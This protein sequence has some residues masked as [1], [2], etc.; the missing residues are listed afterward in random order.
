MQKLIGTLGVLSLVMFL[1]ETA[2][3]VI[4]TAAD[5]FQA[6]AS[7]YGRFCLWIHKTIVAVESDFTDYAM[8]AAAVGLAAFAFGWLSHNML[9]ER[10][11][12]TTVNRIVGLA[13]AAAAIVYYRRFG[14]ELSFSNFE[15]VAVAA[16]SGAAGALTVATL[17][18]PVIVD[19][20]PT[21]PSTQ[22]IRAQE[23]LS[24]IAAGR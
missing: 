2:K 6:Q 9:H 19:T 23:R 7:A 15:A 5:P 22:D 21:A 12:G 14:G 13:G 20:P 24:K 18:K 11:F 4:A 1:R 16:L 8:L 10:G 3:S 17:V